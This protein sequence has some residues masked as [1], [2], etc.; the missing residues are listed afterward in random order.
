[1]NHQNNNKME[2]IAKDI[3]QTFLQVGDQ[4]LDAPKGCH[5]I[6]LN[7]VASES[8]RQIVY[9]YFH[10]YDDF[11]VRLYRKVSKSLHVLQ[12]KRCYIRLKKQ[13]DSI[14]KSKN[15][16]SGEIN[17]QIRELVRQFGLDKAGV[18]QTAK[19]L[20]KGPFKERHLNSLIA[21]SIADD[22]LAGLKDVFFG[23]GKDLRVP[24]YGELDVIAS[25]QDR[26][27]FI[28]DTES[29]SLSFQVRNRKAGGK[30][31]GWMN[32]EVRVP[33]TSDAGKELAVLAKKHAAYLSGK[34]SIPNG[35]NP[36]RYCAIRRRYCMDRGRV[37]TVYE[38]LVV[39]AGPAPARKKLRLIGMGKVGLDA[40]TFTHA[41]V[42]DD[43][44]ALVTPSPCML[45]LM[46]KVADI[47]RQMD[48]EL[49]EANRAWFAEDGQFRRPEDP[50]VA[51]RGLVKTK[52]YY[53][54]KYR[55]RWLFQRFCDTRRTEFNRLGNRIV[56]LG[57][58]FYVEQMNYKALQKRGVQEVSVTTKD[59]FGNEVTVV[60]TQRKRRF[61]R[62]ILKAAPGLFFQ[63]VENKVLAAGG[64]F[65]RVWPGDIKASQYN[66]LN[67]EYV[68]HGLDER[69]VRV[70]EHGRIQ[71]DLMAANTLRYCVPV[72]G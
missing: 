27:V 53:S 66:P 21:Q 41:I 65:T 63:T 19:E 4:L 58:E 2:N 61:G 36:I 18:Y 22:L 28:F 14:R 33:R 11:K 62:S 1:M 30:P 23:E 34:G 6:R 67:G 15:G 50:A 3:S 13:R 64:K 71:R 12:N 69:S 26:S 56:M 20:C 46:E 60:Q 9:R 70:D 43:C 48:T 32:L 47:E 45:K 40:S 37:M 10:D 42:A 57:D 35:Y 5:V 29:M 59:E 44:L 16:N 7:I 38:L 17:T 54:L 72:E 55:L 24:R 68:K 8:Q 49:R 25:K 52:R 51:S 39:V 31:T